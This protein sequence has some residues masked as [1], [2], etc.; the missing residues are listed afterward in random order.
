MAK[1][2]VIQTPTVEKIFQHYEAEGAKTSRR[3]NGIGIST[4][5]E[6]CERKLWYNF[7]WALPI[8]VF[9]GRLYRLFETGH[10]E[11]PRIAK[12]LEAIGVEV[13]LEDDRTNEQFRVEHFGG[14]VSG[15][16]DGAALGIPEAPKTWHA[17]EFKTHNDRSFKDLVKKGVE[18]AKPAHFVQCMMAMGLT[19]MK[20]ALYIARNKNDDDLYSERIK[21][22]AQVYQENLIK[23]ERIIFTDE[24]PKKISKKHDS[25]ACRFCDFNTLC[26]QENLTERPE[27][28]CRTCLHADAQENGEW[29]CQYKQIPLSKEEQE[30]GCGDHLFL[31]SLLPYTLVSAGED[32]GIIYRDINGKEVTN[33]RGGILE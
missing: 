20:R 22:D 33:K 6:P 13:H 7:R 31:P 15:Y 29:W 26:H 19:G 10:Q 14:H 18:K 17:L 30:K 25:Y 12:N 23:A 1:L 2:P 3:S 8:K 4:L 21:Y 28:N 11:E 16:L 9:T 5:G 24:A 27:T 32:I